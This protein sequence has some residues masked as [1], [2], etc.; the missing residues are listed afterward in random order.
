MTN[1]RHGALVLDPLLDDHG[2]QTSVGREHQALG[3]AAPTSRAP[4]FPTSSPADEQAVTGGPPPS[5]SAVIAT[6]S[7]PGATASDAATRRRSPGERSGEPTCQELTVS[8]VIVGHEERPAVGTDRG[9]EDLPAEREDP[10]RTSVGQQGVEQAVLRVRSACRLHGRRPPGAARRRGSGRWSTGPRAGWR[11]PPSP[12]S[13]RRSPGPRRPAGTS[14]RSPQPRGSRTSAADRPTA[15]RRVRA[16]LAA[17][18][19]ARD[20]GGGE[21]G[22]GEGDPAVEELAL[23]RGD[24]ASDPDAHST[25]A[26]SR[27]PR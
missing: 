16:R 19:S 24:P 4:T 21:L 8:P 10:G 22:L 14:R 25:A 12:R 3:L 11:R 2:E 18:W 15:S 17:S 5:S 7:P 9:L 13:G 6:T 1:E 20:L 23:H 26:S 27:V